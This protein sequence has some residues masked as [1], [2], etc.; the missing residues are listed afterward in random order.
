MDS[1]RWPYLQ[2]RAL[3]EL[4]CELNESCLA[5]D[6]QTLYDEGKVDSRRRLL[7]FNVL[8]NNRGMIDFR[9][10]AP[11]NQW[12]F[13][14]CHDHYHAFDEFAIY[15]L[16]NLDGTLAAEGLKASYCLADSFCFAPR[17]S[18]RYRCQGLDDQGISVGCGD[19]YSSNTPC[20]WIDV[21]NVPLGNYRLVVTVNPK[22]RV[23]EL[24]FSNNQV[25]CNITLE[26]DRRVTSH[27]CAL[28]GVCVCLC[29]CVRVFV[30]ACACV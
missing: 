15:D 5:S 25:Y 3:S 19:L 10:Y 9:S 20:Q 24:D 14:E 29:V 21:T 17:G 11:S 22:G 30:R 27:G 28:R 7:T 2:T 16:R 4:K 1:F 6:A 18:Q 8:S 23:P 26:R 12:E 13:H